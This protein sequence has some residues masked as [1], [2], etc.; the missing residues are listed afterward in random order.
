MIIDAQSQNPQRIM[1]VYQHLTPVSRARRG[2]EIGITQ[3]CRNDTFGMGS[4]RMG[5]FIYI[6]GYIFLRNGVSEP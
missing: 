4:K 5:I 6:Y 3:A 1:F 2:F